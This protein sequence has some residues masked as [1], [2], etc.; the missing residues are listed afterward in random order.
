MENN[1]GGNLKTS[2]VSTGAN[3]NVVNIQNNIDK[4]TGA[5]MA[6]TN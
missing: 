6:L 3:V 1:N 5:I 4:G 2:I